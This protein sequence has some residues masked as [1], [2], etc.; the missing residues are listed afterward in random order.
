MHRELTNSETKREVEAATMH[1]QMDDYK[2]F[3][4]AVMKLA[5]LIA[6]YQ[7]KQYEN[8]VTSDH[9][10]YALTMGVVKKLKAFAA[11]YDQLQQDLLASYPK[12][13]SDLDPRSDAE[14][15]KIWIENQ[16]KTM[17]M[18]ANKRREF[19]ADILPDA[20]YARN[21]LRAR[22]LP[23]P[24]ISERQHESVDFTFQGMLA[25]AYPEV[26]LANYL[27]LYAKPLESK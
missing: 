22:K 11:K 27:E 24:Q 7:K 12:V 20:I 17:Q 18:Y 15:N 25:G 8:K 26:D 13:S 23:E 4:P 5:D 10:L 16:N 6:E 1:Q 9:D 14:K 19:Q 21:A 3:G 2:Q